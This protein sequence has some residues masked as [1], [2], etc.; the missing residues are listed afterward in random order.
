[1]FRNLYL[2]YIVRGEYELYTHATF[3]LSGFNSCDK[4]KI[5]MTV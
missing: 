3:F 5:V 2:V 4:I 1:M